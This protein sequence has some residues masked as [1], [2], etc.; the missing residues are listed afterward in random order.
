MSKI[1]EIRE[2]FNRGYTMTLYG[3]REILHK[4]M[5]DDIQ[6]LLNLYSAENRWKH[7]NEQEPPT[8]I[9]L[10]VKSPNEIVHLASW[11]EGYKVFTCQCKNESS[12]NWQ[13]KLIN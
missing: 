2:R 10:L 8:N 9:E 3:T 12:S 6:F 1:E 7:V 13:W 5:E 4:Q 11:R